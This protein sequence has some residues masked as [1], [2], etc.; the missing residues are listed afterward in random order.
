MKVYFKDEEE[1]KNEEVNEEKDVLKD[2]N[3]EALEM[4]SNNK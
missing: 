1:K 3:P 4:L 2:I